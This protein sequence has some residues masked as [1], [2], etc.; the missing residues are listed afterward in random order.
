MNSYDEDDLVEEFLEDMKFGPNI[1]LE[2]SPAGTFLSAILPVARN[3]QKDV[4]HWSLPVFHLVLF[5]IGGAMLFVASTKTIAKKSYTYMLVLAVLS[6]AF[7]LALGFSMAIGSLQAL[8]GLVDSKG[9]GSQG[10]TL[11]GNISLHSA[12]R[13]YYLQV[14]QASMTSLF[15]VFMGVMFIGA[16]GRP[17]Y[18]AV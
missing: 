7:A 4:F 8:R 17:K 14:A 18:E 6:T 11:D 10:W 9:S 1:N 12:D 5:V 13:L 15:S 16:S 2:T 3:L